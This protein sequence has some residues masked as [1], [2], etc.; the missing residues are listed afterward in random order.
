MCGDS[1]NDRPPHSETIRRNCTRSTKATTPEN[2]NEKKKRTE[3]TKV[4]KNKCTAPDP[5]FS[6]LPPSQRGHLPHIE[7]PRLAINV[8]EIRPLQ[9]P[10]T[11][12]TPALRSPNPPN[13]KTKLCPPF[14]QVTVGRNQRTVPHHRL[15]PNHPVGKKNQMTAQHR[16]LPLVPPRSHLL[17]PPFDIAVYSSTKRYLNTLALP[18]PECFL[19][20]PAPLPAHGASR[21]VQAKYLPGP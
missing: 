17:P 8:N 6:S 2:K 5:R 10:K 3:H 14:T 11:N 21:S 19:S 1:L 16:H 20:P 13:L 12:E 9:S 7:H 18:P 4:N 15:P